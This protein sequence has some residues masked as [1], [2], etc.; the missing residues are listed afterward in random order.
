M[1]YTQNQFQRAIL[2]SK[3]RKKTREVLGLKSISSI[4]PSDLDRIAVWVSTFCKVARPQLT[5]ANTSIYVCRLDEEE[6]AEFILCKDML[7]DADSV[8]DVISG[9]IKVMRRL[10][11]KRSGEKITGDL[12]K[13]DED[14]FVLLFMEFYL[15][16]PNIYD[17]YS[18]DLKYIQA[19]ERRVDAIHGSFLKRV[20]E[21]DGLHVNN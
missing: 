17:L 16:F 1:I 8:L 13:L 4:S 15:E 11:M 5:Y 3:F 14:A 6:R 20:M 19:V 2:D 9:M 7:S 10:S 12:K 18:N 21:L